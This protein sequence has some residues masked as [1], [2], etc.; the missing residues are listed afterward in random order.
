MA[1]NQ[2]YSRYGGSTRR[3]SA[4][5]RFYVLLTLVVILAVA[6]SFIINVT[7]Q[8]KTLNMSTVEASYLDFEDIKSVTKWHNKEVRFAYL[9]FDDGPSRNTSEILDILDS[10][11]IKGTFFVLGTAISNYS[12]A[13]D[14]LQRMANDGHYIGM[15]SMTHD[16]D[17]LYKDENA[18]QNFVGEIKEQQELISS[19][20]GGFESQLC[21]APYGTGG[22][23]TEEHIAALIEAGIKC[24]D[25]DIDSM[26]WSYNASQIMTKIDS[27]MTLWN[28]PTHTVILF[29]EKDVTVEVLPQVIEYYLDLGYEFLPYNPDSHVIKNLVNSVDL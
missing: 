14:M 15:H 1:R 25:W 16:F 10:Y 27:D 18:A 6:G 3:R 29:H 11:G 8:V 28:K 5:P 19:I 24:W 20:T 22:T 23:F 13:E 2:Y 21:R 26:D 17:Y 9:T 4:K 7:S 12:N